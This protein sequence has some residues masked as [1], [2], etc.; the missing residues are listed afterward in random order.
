MRIVVI[1]LL[2]VVGLVGLGMSLCG[3]AITFSGLTEA[4]HQ[5]EFRASDMMI[6]SVPSLIGG[7]LIL[8]FVFRK[9]RRM[10]DERRRARD[11]G[12]PG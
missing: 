6:I 1:F 7:L 5:G 11:P 9:L 3:G 4:G 10:R 12:A 2:C 8:V